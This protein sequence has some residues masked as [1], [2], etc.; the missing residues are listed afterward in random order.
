MC[1]K[2]NQYKG[3]IYLFQ[4]L[5]FIS[6]ICTVAMFITPLT[7]IIGIINAIKKPEEDAMPSKVMAVIS[8]YLIIIPLILNSYLN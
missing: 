8:A 7:L 2:L 5:N 1:I 6:E 3:E 4:L